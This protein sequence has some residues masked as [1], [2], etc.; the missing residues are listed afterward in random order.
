MRT[1]LDID[2]DILSAAKEIARRR[3]IRTGKVISDLA[4]EGLRR[5]DAF[6]F[7][8]GFPLIPVQTGADPMTLEIVNRLREERN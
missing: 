6:T 4:R 2:D 8:D 7:E 5:D 1:T 3:R